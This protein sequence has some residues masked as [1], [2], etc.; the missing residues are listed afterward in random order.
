MSTSELEVPTDEAGRKSINRQ[1]TIK[2]QA[3]I[4]QTE[5]KRPEFFEEEYEPLDQCARTIQRKIKLRET[6]ST[7]G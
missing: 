5:P 6:S 1:S 3:R 7:K 2:D 4:T